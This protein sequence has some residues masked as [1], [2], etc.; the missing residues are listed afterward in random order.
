VRLVVRKRA[1]ALRALMRAFVKI[2]AEAEHSEKEDTKVS[3]WPS[4]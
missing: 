4:E 3:I 1:G 2:C